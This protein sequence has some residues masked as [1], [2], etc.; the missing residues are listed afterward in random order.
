MSVWLSFVLEKI[1][2]GL[3]V[4]DRRSNS[5]LLMFL[6]GNEASELQSAEPLG[7]FSLPQPHVCAHLAACSQENDDQK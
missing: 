1:C 2:S 6:S 4:W 7:R 3:G 5:G